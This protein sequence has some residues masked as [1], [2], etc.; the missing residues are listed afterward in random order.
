MKRSTLLVVAAASVI[1]ISL[2]LVNLPIM[3]FSAMAALAVLCGAVVRPAWLGLMIPLACRAV[4][5]CVLEYR[6]GHGFYESMM[7]EYLAYAGVFA[8]GRML[9]PKQMPVALGAGILAAMTFFLVSNFGVWCMPHEGTYMYPQTLSGLWNCYVG[10]LPFARGTFLGDVCFTLA[11][12]GALQ[13][14]A[15]PATDTAPSVPAES[16]S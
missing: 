8:I 13:L 6:T 11:F 12:F 7:F 1:A 14:I 3:N 4:T 2:R 5:D 16:R 9:Q 10:G 15:A